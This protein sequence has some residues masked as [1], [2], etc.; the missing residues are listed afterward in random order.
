[1]GALAGSLRRDPD[2]AAIVKYTHLLHREARE[3]AQNEELKARIDEAHAVALRALQSAA[4]GQA[5]PR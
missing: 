1:M 3:A 5:G 2:H 4:I